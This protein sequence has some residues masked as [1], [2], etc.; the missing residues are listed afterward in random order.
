MPHDHELHQDLS[1]GPESGQGDCRDQEDDGR[2]GGLSLRDRPLPPPG[3]IAG[4]PFSD[5]DP[6]FTVIV[7]DYE[8]SVSRD[9]L[10]RKMAS[11]AGQTCKDFEVLVYHDGP[12]SQSYADDMAESPMHPA[13]EFIVTPERIGDWGHAARDLGIRAA[14]GKFIIHTNADNI[15]YPNLIAVLKDALT[16]PQPWTFVRNPQQI[17][18]PASAKWLARMLNLD[19]QAMFRNVAPIEEHSTDP[20]ILVYA[21]I[22]RGNL[23]VASGMFRVFETAPR[24]GV[25]FGGVP[26]KFNNIDAMQLVMKRS[27][28]LAEGGWH[29]RRINS[30][31]IMYPL[32]AGKYR[33]LAI[34]AVLGEHW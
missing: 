21:I 14:R 6:L 1:Q 29:D 9:F 25:V 5:D 8:P 20:D 12:K 11:L 13:T 28:W 19:L 17:R 15:F 33:V 18:I 2:T 7:T 34:P 26:V 30:D 4:R 3:P 31:A 10:R 24:Q 32:F 23:P 27:L 16:D 22:L